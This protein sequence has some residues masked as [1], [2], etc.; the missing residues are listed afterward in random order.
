MTLQ[1][2]LRAL[3]CVSNH[4][5]DRVAW[6][7]YDC[8]RDRTRLSPRHSPKGGRS[9]PRLAVLNCVIARSWDGLKPGFSANMPM[10][11][12][13]LRGLRGNNCRAIG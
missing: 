3:C 2:L 1:E 10:T 9:S 13:A 5:C 4:R 6:L 11:Q 8:S 12:V 7:V